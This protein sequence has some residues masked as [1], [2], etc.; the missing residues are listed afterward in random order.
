MPIEI[1][2]KKTPAIIG[3]SESFPASFSTIEARIIASLK[4]FKGNTVFLL[5]H[6]VD[7]SLKN[8]SCDFFKIFAADDRSL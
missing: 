2:C 7:A 5:D 8:S 4:F 3:F 6:R 1:L